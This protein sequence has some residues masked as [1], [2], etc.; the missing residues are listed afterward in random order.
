M[1]SQTSP[2]AIKEAAI[3]FESGS[4]KEMDI[5]IGVH[6]PQKLRIRRVMERDQVEQEKI[7]ERMSRQMNEEEKMRLCDY[8]IT[9]DDVTAVI[10]QVLSIHKELH[11]KALNT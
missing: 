1:Q 2:Y 3:F 6:A 7:L 5:M 8:V 9:N 11:Q 10:P 4:N